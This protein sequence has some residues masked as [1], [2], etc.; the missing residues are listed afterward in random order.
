MDGSTPDEITGVFLN[1]SVRIASSFLPP[2]VTHEP[3]KGR[4]KSKA[5]LLD[6]AWGLDAVSQLLGSSFSFFPPGS[7]LA[8]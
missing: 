2:A 7:V 4:G 1:E 5:Q 6:G 8:L 3:T